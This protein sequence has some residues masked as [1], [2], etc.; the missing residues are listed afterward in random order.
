MDTP[1]TFTNNGIQLEEGWKKLLEKEFHE[2]YFQQ[3]RNFL[4]EERKSHQVYPKGG[5]IFRAFEETPYQN[6]KVILIGQDPY[7][8]PGQAEGLS[9]SVPLGVKPPPSLINMY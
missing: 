4:V 3:L 6:L 9:F 7:H 1:E 8:G 5:H 2:P